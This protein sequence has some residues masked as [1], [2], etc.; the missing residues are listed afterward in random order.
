MPLT[1]DEVDHYTML[2]SVWRL[3]LADVIQISICRR[4]ELLGI[5][6]MNTARLLEGVAR[7]IKENLATLDRETIEDAYADEKL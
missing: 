6:K 5:S 7:D 4:C 3:E 2:A 1:D